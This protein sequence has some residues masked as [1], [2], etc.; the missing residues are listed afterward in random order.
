MTALNP[1]TINTV[2]FDFDD[3]LRESEPRGNDFFRQYLVSQ[4]HEFAPE[5]ARAAQL[6]EH[7]YWATSPELLADMD[8]FDGD[9]TPAFWQNYSRLNMRALGLVEDEAVRLAPLVHAH[10]REHYRPRNLLRPR[11]L[12]TL[13][14]LRAAGLSLGMLTNRSRAVYADMHAL[15]LDLYMDFYLTG[16]QL[17]AYKPDKQIFLN[18]LKFIGRGPQE[19][20]YVGDNYYADVVG[21]HAAGLPA[22]LVDARGLYAGYD[23]LTIETLDEL[24]PLLELE[25]IG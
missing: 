5:A 21:A 8:A 7:R 19:V 6:W 15:G 9:E 22:V 3:T 25:T 20:L 18:L 4:G 24:L 17:G 12:E 13:A 11:T 23:A 2:V 1:A 14:E 16:G 10:M